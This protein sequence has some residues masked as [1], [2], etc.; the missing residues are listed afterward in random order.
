MAV[1]H[2]KRFAATASQL[3]SIRAML[4]QYV[5][6][7]FRKVHSDAIAERQRVGN[8]LVRAMGPEVRLDSYMARFDLI[9]DRAF[10]EHYA[11]ALP[12]ILT[13]L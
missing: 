5:A 7:H 8:T 4:W 13:R 11:P 6:A 12:E 1:L 2:S 10:R 3:E 9:V